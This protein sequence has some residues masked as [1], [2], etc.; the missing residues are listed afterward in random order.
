[1]CKML[2]RVKYPILAGILLGLTGGVCIW[3]TQWKQI[4]FLC[5]VLVLLFTTVVVSVPEEERN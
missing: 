3:G 2:M 1:M 5:L 4:S